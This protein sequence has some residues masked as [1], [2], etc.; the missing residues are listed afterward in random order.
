MTTAN[1]GQSEINQVL[2]QARFYNHEIGSYVMHAIDTNDFN[3]S[4]KLTN[5][6]IKITW[7]ELQDRN[8]LTEEKKKSIAKRLIKNS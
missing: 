6:M 2:S 5:G 1:Y 4:V 3:Y 8:S 7:E